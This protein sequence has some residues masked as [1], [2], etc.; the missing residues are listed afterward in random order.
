MGLVSSILDG[1][2]AVVSPRAAV[3][4]RFARRVL[5]SGSRRP[6]ALRYEAATVDRLRKAMHSGSADGDLLP[7]LAVLRTKS[8]ALVRD[9]AHAAAAI[10]VYLENVVGSGLIAQA[11]NRP[12]DTGLSQE[13]CDQLNEAQEAIWRRW[14]DRLAD[15]TEVEDFHGLT[16]MI[17]RGRLVD[18]ES[19][20]HRVLMPG[21]E[22]E[23]AY[24]L[25]DPG[26][27]D[28]LFGKAN[29]RYGIEV[30]DRGQPV[31]YWVTPYHPDDS[32][33]LPVKDNRP[34]RIDRM[35]NGV[36][37]MLHVYRRDRPGQSRGLPLITPALLL[38]EQLHHYLDSEV[39]AARTNANTAAIV[40][41]PLESN[42]PSL[43][44]EFGPDGNGSGE[45]IYHEAIQPGTYQYLNPGEKFSSYNPQRP[46]TTFD[47]FVVRILR[48]IAGSMGI[49][50]EMIVKDFSRMNFTSSRA[51]LGEVRRGLLTEQDLLIVRWCRPAWET[52]QREAIV[53]GKVPMFP[54]MASGDLQ[55]FLSA[56]WIRPALGW[57]DP[58]KEVAASASAIAENLSTRQVEALR[59]G[60]DLEEIL[61]ASAD[62]WLLRRAIE[63]RRGLPEGTL[64]PAPKP[65]SAPPPESP[66]MPE[67]PDD[68][69]P[70]DPEEDQ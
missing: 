42:D 57:I 56:R 60:M 30:G 12:Q 29:V 9:D 2:V 24:E 27:V 26:R 48:A 47:P 11:N 68:P 54:Q 38:F 13:Q 59:S 25:V 22:I 28:D 1:L 51:K 40:E 15:S 45:A 17:C 16:R 36:P 58:V 65:G 37:N 31:A 52:V 5:E 46:G 14:C 4:R 67:E 8:N 19:F 49:S 10:R 3:E 62:E 70:P 33:F 21:R 55:R 41:R 63:K 7:D 39:I 35:V 53:S 6:M 61:E 69:P 43:A 23:T 66:S 64:A 50:Y 34:V 32:V 20:V 44:A 18:G